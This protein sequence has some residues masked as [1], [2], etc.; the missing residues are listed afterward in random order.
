MSGMLI[1][2]I[3]LLCFAVYILSERQKHNQIAEEAY[4]RI[5]M[6]STD[7]ELMYQQILTSAKLALKTDNPT[8][9][10]AAVQDAII[11]YNKLAVLL[12]ACKADLLLVKSNKLQSASDAL[13]IIQTRINDGKER[14]DDAVRYVKSIPMV[15][16]N[17]ARCPIPC[18]AAN[19][20]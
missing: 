9:S 18:Y 7:S 2:L 15:M 5:I 12:D 6:R 4:Q 11:A 19:P 16:F 20:Q 1:V 8:D 17:M 13:L 14:V 3:I 10:S